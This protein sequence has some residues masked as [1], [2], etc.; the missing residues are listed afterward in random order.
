VA[1]S[2]DFGSEAVDASTLEDA[3]AV[4]FESL[5]VAVLRPDAGAHGAL[6]A[7]AAT[8]PSITIE[9]ER[10]LYAAE[11]SA[12]LSLD[13][14]RGFYDGVNNFPPG[15]RARLVNQPDADA[16]EVSPHA[17]AT[18]GLQATRVT[19]SP[20]S[21]SGIRVAVL[22]TGIDLQHP[23]FAGRLIQSESFVPEQSVQDLHGHGT[24]CAGTACGPRQSGM[25][26]RYGVAYDA[27][28]FVGKVL[29]NSGR[30]DEGW[31]LAGMNWAVAH[32]CHVISMSLSAP[33]FPG[34]GFSQAHEKIARTAL[35]R[36][37][38]I[39]AA[40]GND[41]RRSMGHIA[42]VGHPA[43]CP[44]IVSVAAVD[45]GMQ[46]ADFSNRAINPDG[47]E[48]NLAGPGVDVYS[49]WPLPLRYRSIGG[50]SMAT[51]HVAGIAA[52]WAQRDAAN[53]GERLRQVL[54]GSA[55]TLGLLPIDAGVGLVQ[56]PL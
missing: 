4:I 16:A 55:A 2:S 26:A 13:Y 46:I 51:P 43:N 6:L 24:H 8:E 47:G 31:I 9:P 22:D 11:T 53:T 56:A 42:A 15:R 23:D 37:T 27:E 20:N 21:G 32:R 36:G 5:G 19:S 52:L 49:S 40:A 41:S 28:L 1:S 10:I 18:W 50:T 12:G 38:V 33:V 17:A 45:V 7:A 29:N 14:L 48:I 39:I 44:S 34:M 35:A 54:L 30:G 3:G 25:G